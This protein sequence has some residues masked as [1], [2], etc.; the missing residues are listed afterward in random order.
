MT[1]RH[2]LPP[3]L[4]RLSRPRWSSGAAAW[5]AARL[6]QQESREVRQIHHLF[7][8]LLHAYR[9]VFLSNLFCF[10]SSLVLLSVL[11]WPGSSY[12]ASHHVWTSAPCC[13]T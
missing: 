13:E 4:R 11:P 7:R 6:L 3:P 10:S 8:F 1:Y 12:P 5:P 9:N 2:P